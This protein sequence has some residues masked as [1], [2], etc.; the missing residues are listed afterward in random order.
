MEE[1]LGQAE[2]YLAAGVPV[3]RYLTDQLM[4]PLGI[5]AHFGAGGGVFRTTDLSLHAATHLDI[6][7]RFLEVDVQVDREDDGNCLVRLG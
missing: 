7:R 2:E 6:L 5:V 1:A 3:G 4:L